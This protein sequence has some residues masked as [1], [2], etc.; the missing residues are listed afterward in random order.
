MHPLWK[1]FALS[2]TAMFVAIDVIGMAPLF[3]GLTRSMSPTD[4]TGV[5]NKSVFVA[6]AVALLFAVLGTSIFR[7]LG[8]GVP[9]FK[10]AGG[11]ILLLV[12]LADLLHGHDDSASSGAT[13]VVPLAVPLITGPGLITTVILQ[14]ASSGYLVA[15]S[16]LLLNFAIV[17]VVL[18]RSQGIARVIG[19]DGTVVVS[20]IV[21]LLLAAIAVSMMR[22]GFEEIVR[23]FR[24]S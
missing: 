5:L 15:L 13:G 10:I 1:E 2:F 14:V 6:L 7:F 24:T 9:D 19:K 8:I 3:L 16:A 21:A 12:S 17:W 20:K 11:L 22:S 4:R 18:A 23:A